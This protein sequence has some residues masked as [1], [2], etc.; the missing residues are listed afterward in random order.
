MKKARSFT[1]TEI[2]TLKD[3]LTSRL[4]I[5]MI[6]K[7][8]AKDPVLKEENWDR[9]LPKFK[10]KNVQRKKIKIKEKKPYTPCSL[11]VEVGMACMVYFP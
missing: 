9:F 7:E 1:K 6:K 3:K 10:G 8:L 5:L 11:S 2:I 4:Q